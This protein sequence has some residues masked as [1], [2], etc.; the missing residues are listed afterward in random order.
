MDLEKNLVFQPRRNFFSHPFLI[1]L[2]DS[3]KRE[4]EATHMRYRWFRH[5]SERASIC[6]DAGL[7]GRQYNPNLTY[8]ESGLQAPI[9]D[10]I[11]LRRRSVMTTGPLVADGAA[12]LWCS[13]I[14]VTLI[15]LLT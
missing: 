12:A 1:E 10:T 7:V 9:T 14:P 2:N 11:T 8:F 5:L 4:V 15:F 13:N 6:E 3:K